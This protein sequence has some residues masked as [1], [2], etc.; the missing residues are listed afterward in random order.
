RTRRRI[1][2][3]R[4]ST[5]AIP[6][7]ARSDSGTRL[8]RPCSAM[9]SPPIPAKRTGSPARSRNA[10]IS[11]PPRASPD[12]SPAIMK[13]NGAVWPTPLLT[14]RGALHQHAPRTVAT[15]PGTAPQQSV[16]AFRRLDPEHQPLLDD[17]RLANIERANRTGETQTALD[18]G[19]SLGTRP[20]PAERT[21]GQ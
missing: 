10:A 3:A 6:A 14:G 9:L 16:S 4:G 8:E 7:T 11:A 2:G 15:Q 20:A 18:I 5:S 21:L 13:M 17:D 19:T 12:G 1:S